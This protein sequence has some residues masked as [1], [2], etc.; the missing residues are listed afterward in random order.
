MGLHD[1]LNKLISNS[2]ITGYEILFLYDDEKDISTFHSDRIYQAAKD[3]NK[4]KNILMIIKSAG[5]QIEPAY[6]ISKTCKR[7]SKS[8]FNIVIPR[9]AK[10]AATTDCIGCK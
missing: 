6:L 1:H 10:S 9:K 3:I 4:K 7:L 2:G 5:G 8:K